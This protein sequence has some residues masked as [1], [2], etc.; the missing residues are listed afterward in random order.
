MTITES[1]LANEREMGLVAVAFLATE[2]KEK[3]PR[4]I[5]DRF[6]MPWMW[7]PDVDSNHEP[8]D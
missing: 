3:R 1:P 6:L 7:L 2:R 4:K 8:T 5:L